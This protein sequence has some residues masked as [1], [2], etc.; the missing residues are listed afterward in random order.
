MVVNAILKV[1]DSLDRINITL[2]QINTSLG[3]LAA[4]SSGS[5]ASHAAATPA[6]TSA[7]TTARTPA[8]KKSPGPDY[9]KMASSLTRMAGQE[10]DLFNSA[11]NVID[12]YSTDPRYAAAMATMYAA[13]HVT[14]QQTGI[15]YGRFELEFAKYSKPR[16]DM[17]DMAESLG[18]SGI[19]KDK[20]WWSKTFEMK[21]T[22]REAVEENIKTIG[23]VTALAPATE[24]VVQGMVSGM[25]TAYEKLAQ[26]LDTIVKA[27]M[28]MWS[29][30]K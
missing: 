11:G 23:Q 3:A 1:V 15:P 12:A 14:S 16:A 6:P 10:T 24:G 29:F 7:G 19:I 13:Q 5:P 30:Y 2:T 26:A 18:A 17:S 25:S 21:K 27:Q 22:Q 4:P 9:F 20:E 28:A 8:P